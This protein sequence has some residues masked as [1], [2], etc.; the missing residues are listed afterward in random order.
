MKPATNNGLATKDIPHN[1]KYRLYGIIIFLIMLFS[2]LNIFT[3]A[4]NL[5]II[6]VASGEVDP[7]IL[8][9]GIGRFN[10][11]VADDIDDD[12]NTEIVFG[13]YDGYVI[14]IEY[15]DGDFHLEWRS[16]KIG[17]RVWGITVADLIGDPTK[18][19]IAGNGDEEIFVFL[20]P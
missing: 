2:I 3:P 17:H 1:L 19:I 8:G 15:R 11:I 12:G 20:P 10:S 18:E 5:L 16:S 9:S 13:N 14:V 6:G 7:E 4:N